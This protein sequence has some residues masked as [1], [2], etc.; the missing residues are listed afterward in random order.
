MN[1]FS[2]N[3]ALKTMGVYV[4]TR[5]QDTIRARKRI[6]TIG[7]PVQR[8]ALPFGD[9][10]AFCTLPNGEVYSL[11][12]LVSIER[13]MNLD[14]IAMCYTRERPRFKREFERARDAGAKVYLLIENGDWEKAY[15]GSYRSQVKPEALTASII[16]WLARYN[17][18][19]LFCKEETSGKLIH[20]VLFR[21]LKERL[22]ALPDE[23][24]G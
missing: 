1:H 11:E 4:D 6:Q 12:N 2:V 22:E 20:D 15:T 9:Y 8:K 7:L 19:L 3:A 17:C 23:P 14:E 18:Q 13:K 24:N 5:E 16:A 10:S 21:E